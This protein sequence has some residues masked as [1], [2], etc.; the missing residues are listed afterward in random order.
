MR[1][2]LPALIACLALAACTGGTIYYAEGVDIP[3]RDR[4]TATCELQ[5][6]TEFP[7]RTEIR[8]TPRIYVPPRRACNSEGGC[9]TRPGYFEGGERY[10]VDVNAPGRAT[11]ARGCMAGRGYARVGLPACEAGTE[12]RLST[13]MPPL[14]GGTGLYS[15]GPGPALVMNPI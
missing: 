14:A 11:A 5:A 2:T 13:V 8:Y 15:P 10:T 4:D 12:V 7:V 6:L 3:T 9:V 1:L